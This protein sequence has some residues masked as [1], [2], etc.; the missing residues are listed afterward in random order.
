MNK[1]LLFLLIL[2]TSFL[3]HENAVSQTIDFGKSY[4]NLTKGLNGGT[5]EPGDVLEI[6][7]SFVVRSGVVDSCSFTDNIPAGTTFIPGTIRV[8]TNEGKIYKQ[9]TDA[10]WDDEGWQ[11]GTTIRINLGYNQTD[12]P[13]RQFRRG[14]LRNTHKPSFYNSAC[15]MVASYQVRV[16]ASL[17]NIIN[18][19][20]GSM[21]YKPGA[22]PEIR[23]TFPSNAVMV[24]T[25]M[26]MC[27][28]VT[29]INTLGTEFNGS[30]GSGKPR[31][32]G[33]SGNVPPSY[34]YQIFTTNTPNDYTYG[35]ANNTSTLTN[36]TTSNGW[37]KPDAS[38][39][40]HRVFSV[41]DIIGDH[42][43]ATNPL[44]GNNAADTVA[45]NNGGYMLVVNASYRIDSAFQHTISG[46]CP[47]TY[48][49]ISCWIRNICSKCGCDSNGRGATGGAGYIP[50]V[51]APPGTADSSGVYP[52]I[53]FEVDGLDYY[54]TGNVKYTGQ[55]VKKGFTILTGPSQTSFTLKFFNNAPGGGGND[56]ALDDIAVATCFPNLSVTP[57]IFSGCAN[58][59][60][61]F[62]AVVRSYFSNYNY[63]KWQISTDGGS[64]W[65]NTGVSGIATPMLVAGQYEYTANYPPFIANQSDSG[66][67]FRIVVATTPG[68]L[69][70]TSCSYTDIANVTTLRIQDCMV[71]PAGIQ[72]FHGWRQNDDVWLDWESVNEQPDMEMFVEKSTDG[73]NF[74]VIQKING[75]GPTGGSSKYHVKDQGKITVSTYYRI[76]LVEGAKHTLS[77][78]ITFNPSGKSEWSIQRVVNPFNNNI[79]LQA[80]IPEK[81]KIIFLL[82]DT[83]GRTILR[84]EQVFEKG[85]FSCSIPLKQELKKGIYILTVQYA[86]RSENVKLMKQ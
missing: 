39:P 26:G 3:L 7:A 58:N 20:G 68:N 16:T 23:Y 81:G 54:S 60:A 46:L 17:G 86:N 10:I 30:F 67:R 41:W 31:N 15:I 45:N 14:R 70:N 78:T 27:P 8:I 13:A 18:I 69:G 63:Y 29:G 19:G 25:N 6:R 83:Y 44:L 28:D 55:W 49:E 33:T 2:M 9:F 35:I 65:S 77:N 72:N 64:S 21:T 24:Y 47:N 85:T 62:G 56:W 53:T 40:T 80:S 73:I 50:T 59:P 37:A 4:V 38:A 48:Y 75:N 66:K 34:S 76:R 51:V 5:I 57:S 74:S 43:G 61:Y 79:S 36:Y 32:R 22:A 11:L 84:N 52:N 71:L 82:T 42:T 1:T 12:A